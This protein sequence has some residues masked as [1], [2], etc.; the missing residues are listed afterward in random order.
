M[1]IVNNFTHIITEDKMVKFKTLCVFAVAVV[2]ILTLAQ[3]HLTFAAAPPFLTLIEQL[4]KS[5]YFDQNLSKNGNQSCATCHDPSVGYTGPDSTLNAH[6]AVYPGSTPTLFGNRKPPSA[7][8]AGDSPLFH[9]DENLGSWIGG[10]FWDG[11][12][13]GSELADPLAEQAKGP[14]LNPL[15]Q[16]ITS[17]EELCKM[18]R[19]GSYVSL[20]ETVWG[21]GSLNCAEA[22]LVYDRIGISIAAYERSVEVNPYSS[23][24]DLFWDKAKTKRLDVTRINLSNWTKY[25][26]LGLNDSELYGLAIF[27]DPASANCASC[28]SLKPGSKGYPLFTDYSYDNLGIPRNLEN[29]FYANSAYNPEGTAWV[30]YGL[31]GY[32]NAPEEMGKM[33][34]PTLRNVD[35]RPST[36]FVKA[37]GHNGYFKSL[38]D[39]IRFYATRGMNG[40]GGGGMGGGGMG[41]GGMGGM[42]G[43]MM[44]PVPEVDANLA[45]LNHFRCAD[46]SYILTFL[47]TLSDG[48]F[49]R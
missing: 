31:G 9:Y 12:A 6:G 37:Y 24:F 27:N 1:M 49:Q 2:I 13:T 26:R 41:G 22:D 8:Y 32:L 36:D 40:M 20:F 47:K 17:P 5:L 18:V 42:C 44:F 30:D 38:P 29:P 3:S 45:T 46:Q 11:R 21:V 33:K 4:G 14:F 39:I 35:K 28:H 48:Y 23:K 19:E 15:E 25:R 34:V 10:M 43:G 7:A 16:G